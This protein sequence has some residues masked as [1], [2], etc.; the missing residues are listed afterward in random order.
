MVR[1]GPP[2][3]SNPWGCHKPAP[4]CCEVT[5]SLRTPCPL[6]KKRWLMLT[7]AA[8]PP[9]CVVVSSFFCFP[10]ADWLPKHAGRFHR[11]E[12]TAWS[13]GACRR[14]GLA[15]RPGFSPRVR[16]FPRHTA[17]LSDAQRV[18]SWF[19]SARCVITLADRAR[20]SRS[21][22]Q[23]LPVFSL[24]PQPPIVPCLP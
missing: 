14:A 5:L 18:P 6:Q 21:F 3:G 12:I 22:S 2:A 24:F 23:A 17:C 10:Q 8:R 19:S 4:V 7:A 15:G 1:R 16:C 9:P 11:V 20:H 13:Y